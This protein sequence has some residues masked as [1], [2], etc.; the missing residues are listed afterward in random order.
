[1]KGTLRCLI[2]IVFVFLMYSP[3]VAQREHVGLWKGED[4]GEVGYINLSPYGFAYMVLN[5]DTLGGE[6]FDLKGQEAYMKYEID[7]SQ[8]VK[9]ID[10]I[11]YLRAGD[12][13]VKTLP[14]IFKYDSNNN[15]ILCFNFMSEER[16]ADF[17]EKNTIIL[18]KVST[19]DNGNATKKPPKIKKQM[20]KQY[21][22]ITDFRTYKL[23]KNELESHYEI[24]FN[25]KGNQTYST[26]HFSSELDIVQTV[27]KYK[28]KKKRQK[29]FYYDTNG[30]LLF[31]KQKQKNSL[32]FYLPTDLDNPYRY[33]YYDEKGLISTVSPYDNKKYP[34]KKGL[35]TRRRFNAKGGLVFYVF[36]EYY[37][38]VGVGPLSKQ[39][40]EISKE[41][42]GQAGKSKIFEI[43]YEYY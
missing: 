36:T 6:S 1:M 39:A 11:A 19:T 21:S 13:K 29:I 41:G 22:T 33:E 2:A 40:K 8:P 16:P 17:D 4:K 37:L 24:G 35:V 15:M 32:M 3:S 7:D 14:G 30:G 31:C 9:S 27:I 42:L 43:E 12:K 34:Y 26:T 10:F 38:P 18:K 25:K 23:R 20:V 5:G 28:L